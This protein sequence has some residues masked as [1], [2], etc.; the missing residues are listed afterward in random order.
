MTAFTPC[1]VETVLIETAIVLAAAIVAG[2]ERK[3]TAGAGTS[4]AFAVITV[5]GSTVIG[6]AVIVLV[7]A[8]VAFLAVTVPGTGVIVIGAGGVA[9]LQVR[10]TTKLVRGRPWR[11]R[12]LPMG[13]V[14][15]EPAIE[16]LA[17]VVLAETHAATRRVV[18][19][20]AREG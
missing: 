16:A 18:T 9:R 3:G 15:A 6:A 11:F 4:T 20:A 17:G 8:T 7:V 1:P 12:P 5:T 19:D 10:P 13:R 14:D 2:G